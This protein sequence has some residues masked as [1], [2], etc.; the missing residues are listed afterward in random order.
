MDEIFHYF[1]YIYFST[2]KNLPKKINHRCIHFIN[3]Y[4]SKYK[5]VN[6]KFLLN[7]S[8]FLQCPQEIRKVSKFL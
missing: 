6:A 1:V 7:I 5:N 3:I 2:H 4:E 8:F